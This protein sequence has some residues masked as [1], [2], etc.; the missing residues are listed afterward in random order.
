MIYN[1]QIIIIN[2]YKYRLIKKNV[3]YIYIKDMI[4]L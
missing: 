4:E 1:T 2:L 3:F